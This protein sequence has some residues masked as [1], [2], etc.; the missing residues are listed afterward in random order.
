MALSL[1]SRCTAS[2]ATGVTSCGGG[3]GGGGAGMP[4]C[5]GSLAIDLSA[6]MEESDDDVL[7]ASDTVEAASNSLAM[8]STTGAAASDTGSAAVTSTVEDSAGTGGASDVFVGLCGCDGTKLST[9]GGMPMRF[10]GEVNSIGPGGGRLYSVTGFTGVGSPEV[11]ID[12]SGGGGV[13]GFTETLS[14]LSVVGKL[15]A[16]D[17]LDLM[18]AVS[19][20]SRLERGAGGGGG[21]SRGGGTAGGGNFPEPSAVVGE[22]MVKGGKPADLSSSTLLITASASSYRARP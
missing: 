4:A 17:A 12:D 9:G 11:S 10:L 15:G 6:D 20:V 3:G 8:G 2:T 16:F 22:A 19:V 21:G 18:E 1:G 13:T 14:K 7:A 5:T